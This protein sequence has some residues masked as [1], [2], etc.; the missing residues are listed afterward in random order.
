MSM[1]PHV[2]YN[3]YMV[4]HAFG[5]WCTVAWLQQCSSCAQ[6]HEL[7]QSHCGNNREGTLFLWLHIYYACLAS[8]RFEHCLS[9][10][11]YDQLCNIYIH[12]QLWEEINW[13]RCE[14]LQVIF[15][16]LALG[17]WSIPQSIKL[18]RTFE[19]EQY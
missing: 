12:R 7:P 15:P 11:T 9:W 18:R 3:G 4:Y 10:V 2:Y 14:T 17:A 6:V 5:T 8:V 16:Y 19:C 13:C 1:C